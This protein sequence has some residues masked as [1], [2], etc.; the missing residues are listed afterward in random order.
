MSQV[1]NKNV[2]QTNRS[3]IADSRTLKVAVAALASGEV[4]MAVDHFALTANN[5]TYGVAGDSIG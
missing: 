5:I 3:N 1:N 4:L 2:F